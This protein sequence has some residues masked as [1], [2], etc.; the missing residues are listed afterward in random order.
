MRS[1]P[2]LVLLP[3]MDGTGEMFVPFVAALGRACKVLCVR[4][5]GDVPLGYAELEALVRAQLPTRG[6][7]VVLGESFSGPI[8]ASLSATPPPG[9]VGVV[10][11]CTFVRN[12]RPVFGVF[13]GLV[14][15]VPVKLA[16]VAAMAAVLLGTH[17]TAA[18]RRAL[19]A[20][21]AQVSH[22]TLRARMRAVLQ[23]DV[24][25]RLAAAQV[26][27]LYL[28]ARQDYLLPAR[29]AAEVQACLPSV[30]VESLDGP[31]LLL[32]ACPGAAADAVRRFMR[33]L[34]PAA[35]G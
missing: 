8:A 15:L 5:P 13:G 19:T 31:H 26:P 2:T 16:P 10:L 33:G 18:L 3:G 23:V 17:S 14:D 9:L 35:T 6:R 12:P 24:R 28:Q 25:T 34:K 7:Y 1:P 30:Q 27:V 20:A 22:A 29:A 11:C 4:Y 21:L 32:Q